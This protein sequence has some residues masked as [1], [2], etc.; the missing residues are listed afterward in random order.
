MP[1]RLNENKIIVLSIKGGG[2]GCVS[3]PYFCLFDSELLALND[4]YLPQAK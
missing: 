2:T 1:N 3:S 4:Y